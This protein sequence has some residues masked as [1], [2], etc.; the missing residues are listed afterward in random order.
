M[1]PSSTPRNLYRRQ[2]LYEGKNHFIFATSALNYCVLKSGISNSGD[3]Y[4]KYV[5]T[6]TSTYTNANINFELNDFDKSIN[7]REKV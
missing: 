5:C 6:N 4:T 2:N 1:N 3:K 7:A